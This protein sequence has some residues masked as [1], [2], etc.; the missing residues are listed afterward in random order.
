MFENYL[1]LAE[2]VEHLG[3]VRGRTRLQK[4]IFIAQSLG[5]PFDEAYQFHLYGPYSP[6][7]AAELEAMKG[8]RLLQET[9]YMSQG[10]T[11]YRYTVVPTEVNA[12]RRNNCHLILP[13]ETRRLL[14]HLNQESTENLEL[15]ASLLYF[16]RC[17]YDRRETLYERM[18]VWKPKF[19]REQIDVGLEK[20][21]NL[22]RSSFY[23]SPS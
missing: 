14:T 22:K 11:E 3:E 23:A 15:L 21:E 7:L 10:Y 4:M 16:Q 13:E 17:G 12:L 6:E 18:G 20:L 1:K 9:P 5:H 8:F 19:T 2:V